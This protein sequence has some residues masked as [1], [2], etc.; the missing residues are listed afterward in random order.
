MRVPAVSSLSALVQENI[1][2]GPRRLALVLGDRVVTYGD[3]GATIETL[4]DHL[5]G[6]VAPGQ[7]VGIIAP[8][9]PALVTGMFAAWR[10]GAVA[11]PLN[12]RWREFELGRVLRDAEVTALISV[13]SCLGF[14]FAPLLSTLQPALNALRRCLFVDELGG[15][16]SLSSWEATAPTMPLSPEIALLLYTSGTTGA[17]KGALITH[18]SERDGAGAMNEILGTSPDD[19]TLL[20]VPI[21]HAFGLMCYLAVFAAGGQAVLVESTFSAGP[22]MEAIRGRR[23]TILHG[24]PTLFISML[25]SAHEG[26]GSLRTGFV[27]GS[28]C[29]GHLLE[30]LDSA[31]L[32]I[33]NLYGMTEI[34]AATCCRPDDPPQ[35]RYTTVGRPL[36]GYTFR[37]AGGGE[38]G[39]VQVRGPSIT[40]GYFRQP[41]QTAAIFE[42]GW[43]RTGDVGALD[44]RGDLRLSGRAK[45]VIHVAGLNVFPAEVETLLL[46]HPDVLHAAVVGVPERTMGE[47]PHA[48]V[49]ARPGSALRPVTLLQ[50]ARP[51]IAGYK[52]P[53]TIHMLSEMPRL[54]SGKPDRA[55][56]AR[57]ISRSGGR[58]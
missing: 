39:E 36:P 14:D 19:V 43:F 40:P 56:L 47:V 28:P 32:R 29:P 16:R 49:V 13:E 1:A 5:A 50:Y 20:V 35:V 27:A 26:L 6:A 3:L 58:P 17:P 4:A 44:A 12:V 55:A 21:T 10:L 48:F 2:L 7:R 34:G 42:D 45:E 57:D 18:Q 11:V 9:S 51:R 22:M 23:A 54:A 24:S 30:Q 8:N 41:G 37:I 31:G 46:G 38:T 25:R 52:L 53:Y 15:I 33:L